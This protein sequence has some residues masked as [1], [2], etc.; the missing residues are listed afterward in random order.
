MRFQTNKSSIF[1]K[2]GYIIIR[3]LFCDREL[4]PDWCSNR[5]NTFACFELRF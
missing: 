4:A 2:V 3:W 1:A 5:K